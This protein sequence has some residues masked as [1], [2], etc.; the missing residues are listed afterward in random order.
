MLA[1]VEIIF[2]GSTP[3]SSIVLRLQVDDESRDFKPEVRAR[4]VKWNCRMYVTV[5]NILPVA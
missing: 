3:R 2:V 4:T 1:D 5:P